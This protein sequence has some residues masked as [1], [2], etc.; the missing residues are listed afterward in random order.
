M[1]KGKNSKKRN[2]KKSECKFCN[3]P[4]IPIIIV[5]WWSYLEDKGYWA[6]PDFINSLHFIRFIF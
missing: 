2:N 4:F 6:H 5:R 1:K 3:V